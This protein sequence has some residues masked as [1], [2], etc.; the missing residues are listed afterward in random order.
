MK[1]IWTDRSRSETAQR[2]RRLRWLE[3]HEGSAERGLS[4]V[5]KSIHLVSYKKK[6]SER[7]HD[8][9][10]CGLQIHRDI[11]AARNILARA[12]ARIGPAELNAVA[13]STHVPESCFTAV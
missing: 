13:V 7:Q 3:Y 8:C 1:R 12:L 10:E 9:P 2:C 4:P 6:M 5:R 11:N